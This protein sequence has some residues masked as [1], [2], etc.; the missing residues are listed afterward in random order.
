MTDDI[1]KGITNYFSLKTLDTVEINDNEYLQTIQNTNT[2]EYSIQHRE[3]GLYSKPVQ[4]A[5][6]YQQEKDAQ[7][8]LVAAQNGG[9]PMIREILNG[10]HEKQ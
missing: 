4:I 9:F 6:G 2:G 1:G 5:D 10:G 3:H 8:I 7:Q